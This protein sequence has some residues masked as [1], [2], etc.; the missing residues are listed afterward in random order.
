MSVDLFGDLIPGS[1]ARAQDLND[2]F[3]VIEACLNDFGSE[4]NG[5]KGTLGNNSVHED[6]IQEGA[7]TQDKINLTVDPTDDLHV[8]TRQ[9]VDNSLTAANLTNAFAGMFGAI[10][11]FG[12]SISVPAGVDI[13]SAP[14]DT[15]NAG[16]TD[17]KWHFVSTVFESECSG[18]ITIIEKKRKSIWITV[19]ISPIVNS[20][21][22]DAH[23][24]KD[25]TEYVGGHDPMD[26][27]VYHVY[28]EADNEAIHTHN[29]PIPKGY[30]VKV[31]VS[32]IK[33]NSSVLSPHTDAY[34]KKNHIAEQNPGPDGDV[35]WGDQECHS[36]KWSPFFTSG[37]NNMILKLA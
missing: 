10:V 28:K 4:D 1:I 6:A 30:Y 9:Y 11:P 25:P 33:F 22:D 20:E 3:D 21:F 23:F 32:A 2:K 24:G 31:H 36:I 35:R 17:G 16:F 27:A 7:I 12:Y 18:Y 14:E 37:D 5:S 13:M 26:W 29:I 34:T 8:A 19:M 15:V